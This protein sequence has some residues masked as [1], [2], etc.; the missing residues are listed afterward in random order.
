MTQPSQNLRKSGS[1]SSIVPEDITIWSLIPVR[2]SILN[3]IGTLGLTNV[4]NLSTISPPFIFTAPISMTLSTK[5][6]KPVV[7]R[8]NTTNS[9][10]KSCPSGFVTILFVSSTR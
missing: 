3:D 9:P 1:I 8:S 5:A 6:E 10:E 2:F 4:E 7:S